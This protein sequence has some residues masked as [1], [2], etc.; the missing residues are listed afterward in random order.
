MRPTV[1]R[2]LRLLAFMV[3]LLMVVGS[4]SCFLYCYLAF[5][6]GLAEWSVEGIQHWLAQI[7]LLAGFSAPVIAVGW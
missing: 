3:G 2:T 7:F 6:I 4:G 1:G 5:N